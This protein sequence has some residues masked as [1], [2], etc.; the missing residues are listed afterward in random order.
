MTTVE[1]LYWLPHCSTC[2]KA[3]DFLLEK[4]VAIAATH[5]MKADRLSRDVIEQLAAKVGGVEA[6]FSKRSMKYR[7][8]GLHEQTLSET[9]MLDNMEK[10]Y[11]FIKRPVVVFDDGRAICG[12]SV[13]QY[14]ALLGS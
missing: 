13:K 5:D 2:V 11:T 7:A 4:G 8:W 12:F 3:Q 9:D 10:E 6:L 14:E 1:T